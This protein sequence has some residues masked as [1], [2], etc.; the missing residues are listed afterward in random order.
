MKIT[1]LTLALT[2]IIAAPCPALAAPTENTTAMP[3]FTKG[4]TLAKDAPHDWTLGPTGARGWIFTANGHSRE[5]R[6]ILVTAVAKD[7]P[8]SAVLSIGDVILGVGGNRFSG[9]AR[10]QFAN[11]IATAESETGG[12]KLPLLRWRDGKTEAVEVKLTVLG[13]YSDMAPYACAKSKRI[14]EMGCASLA[15]RMATADYAMAINAKGVNAMGV[16]PITRSLNALA[17]LASGNKDYL[18]L[19]KK[20]AQWAADFTS[21]NFVSWYYGYVLAFLSEYV[22][23]TGDPSVM[24]GIKRFALEIAHGQ[25][26][27][28]TWGHDFSDTGVNLKGY[29]AMNAPGLTLT[30]GLVLARDAGVKEPEVDRAIAKATKLL[31]WYLDKGAI[32]YGDHQPF[33]AHEDNGKCAAAAVLFDMVGD[34]EAAEFFAKMTTAAYS[35]RERGHTG[36]Y[37]NILWA[38]PGVARCGPLAIGAYMREHAWYYDLA[39]G[40]DTSFGYQGSPVGEEEHNKYTGWD[41]SGGYLLAYALPLK[42]LRLTGKKP[43]IVPPLDAAQTAAVIAAGRDYTYKGDENLYEKRSSEQLLTG[44]SSWSPFVR[45]R[46]AAALGKREGDFVPTLLKLLTDKNRDTRYG[47]LEALGA[48]GPRADAAA[49]QIRAALLDSDPWIQCLATKALPELGPDARKA[50]VSDL[51]ALIVRQNPADP[52]H[53]AAR[54]ASF[55]LFAPMPGERGP[56][57]ILAES[58]EG[59]DRVKLIPALQALL[60]HEDSI[61]RGSVSNTYPRL[62]DAELVTLLPSIVKAIEKLAPSNEMFGDT[63]RLAGL[64]LLSRLQ[65]SEGMALCVSVMEPNRW[66]ERKRYKDCLTYLGR[67]GANAKPLLPKLQ[68]IRTYF[69][70]VAQFSPEQLALVDKL[71]ADIESSTA[72]PTLVSLAEFRT[73]PTAK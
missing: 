44:L 23:A 56:R 30:I 25:G 35:E 58:L 69:A 41:C 24:P 31:R 67:Y 60:A 40:W 51:L 45:G 18:P 29:G 28:G 54:S 26:A 10:I 61:P 2:A 55:A 12:G 27:V 11:A 8:A 72:T 47:A 9:D 7:S 68:E 63:I 13:S 16:N 34:R 20:E 57:S 53:K 17:L 50:S 52:R 36:N 46:S 59:V 64:D 14:F 19:I 22:M 70:T 3:D 49:P 15:Q 5:A 71:V 33:F 39:R 43:F 62:T 48:L 32:P 37:L 42:S 21:P 1:L 66:G 38:L 73:R 65:I 4:E 6:Q